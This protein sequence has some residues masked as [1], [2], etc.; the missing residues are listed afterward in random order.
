MDFFSLVSIP[1][2]FTYVGLWCSGDVSL[3]YGTLVLSH[4]FG[5]FLKVSAIFLTT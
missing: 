5:A 4:F 2:T 3:V 1:A